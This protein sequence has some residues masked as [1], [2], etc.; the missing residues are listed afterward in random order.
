MQVFDK[1]GKW[2]PAP[3]PVPIREKLLAGAVSLAAILAVLYISDLFLA[4]RDL[5]LIVASMGAASVLLFAIPHGPMS[6]P[7]PLIGG[8]LVSTFIG[9]T[10]VRLI[11]DLF[12]AASVAVGL[13]I[14]VMYLLRCLHPPGGAS[15]L[16]VVFGGPEVVELGYRF[17]LTPLAM[18]LVVLLF[19]ALVINNLLPGRTYPVVLRRAKSE[20]GEG[21]MKRRVLEQALSNLGTYVDVSVDELEQIC[22]L[23][24]QAQDQ[25]F[26]PSVCADIM[27]RQVIAA[28]YD[29]PVEQVWE[30]MVRHRIRSVPVVDRKRF[31]IG[32]IT[33]QDFL[34]Q[35]L[36]VEGRTWSERF[37]KFLVPSSGLE[38]DKPEVVGHLMSRP[39]VT[40][41]EDQPL[42]EV[43]P[44]FSR[45]GFHHL[46]VVDR[47]NKL[48]GIISEHDLVQLL[49]LATV[50]RA[51]PGGGGTKPPPEAAGQQGA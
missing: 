22:T 18:N 27:T 39:V 2:L 20:D 43:M 40:A 11:P 47:R 14:S 41:Y 31:V 32:I 46:P 38:T 4:G 48:A 21:G 24:R 51:E 1:L 12:V 5:P 33:T 42:A 17:L 9:I 30:W 44:L 13:A 50:P 15:A 49:D 7:W 19:A 37:R 23:A 36:R 10:C 34:K 26:G 8:H 6:Q 29:T 45:H 28:E 25:L 16:T 35:V 3:D